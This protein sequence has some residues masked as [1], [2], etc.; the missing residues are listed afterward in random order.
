MNE[1]IQQLR[2][3]V[4]MVWPYRWQALAA[5]ALVC[6]GGWTYVYSLPNQF[7][8]TAKIFI[9]TRSMLRPLLQGL[10]VNNRVLED[11]A[12]LMRQT[13]LT[14]PNLEEV[15]RRTDLDLT[16]KTPREFDKLIATLAEQ[17]QVVG[18]RDNIYEIKYQSNDPKLAKKIV[19]ELLNTFLESALG[20]TRKDTAVT[21][22][23]LDEQIA[24]YERKLIEAE[25]RLKEFKRK[26]IGVMPGSDDDYYAQLKGTVDQ[27]AKAELMLTEATRRRDELARQVEGEEPV[28]GFT[29]PSTLG[30]GVLSQLDARE[31]ALKAKLDQLLLNY[32]EKHPDV[33]AIRS[34]LEGIQAEREAEQARLSQMEPSAMPQMGQNPVY[35]EMR[36]QLGAAEAEVAALQ[37]RVQEYGKRVEALEKLV[38][39]VPEIEAELK[40][41]DRDYGLNKS[42]FEELIKRRESARMSEEA[43]KSADDVK[44]KVIEPPRVP[45]VPSGPERIKLA[46]AVFIASLG[47]GGGLALLLSQI[48][49]RFYTTES[50]KEFAQIPILGSVS[51]VQSGRQRR[52]RRMELVFFGLVFMLLFT[53]YSSLIALQLLNIDVHQHLV[54]LLGTIA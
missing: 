28:A 33:A 44:L 49:P 53:C 39:T 6:A 36:V 47:A 54:S 38:N 20:D 23:F 30:S 48:F 18:Q 19:D 1:Q 32:T 5:S 10:A 9:D 4:R 14:R 40:R 43:D 25:E 50:L 2:S 51:L 17:L 13:L 41:L 16:A 34:T 24:E 37:S 46:S 52:E 21:Q 7:E 31:E 42:Q 15:A 29:D 27:K 8:V 26:N 35:Q 3:Y 45:L 22:K 12:L 11:S